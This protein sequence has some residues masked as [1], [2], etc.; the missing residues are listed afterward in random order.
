MRFLGAKAEPLPFKPVGD[1]I[2]RPGS[3]VS[4]T[5]IKNN[6]TSD[7]AE[8]HANLNFTIDEPFS[9]HKIMAA[10]QNIS[11]D[12]PS[13]SLVPPAQ[14]IKDRYA[15]ER[16]D[17]RHLPFV[18]ID[19]ARTSIID[20]ALYAE[21][22]K[23]GAYDLY[24]AIASTAALIEPDSQLEQE[25]RSR[26]QN[27]YLPGM[28]STM[29]PDQISRQLGTLNPQEDK[30]ALVCKMTIDSQGHLDKET[31][32]FM[33]ATVRSHA[34]L[35]YDTVS[36]H[37]SEGNRLSGKSGETC[38]LLNEIAQK[39]HTVIGDTPYFTRNNDYYFNVD[40]NSGKL[41]SVS[42]TSRGSANDLVQDL[43]ITANI[44]AGAWLGEKQQSQGIYRT[45]PG[46]S[47]QK[48]LKAVL[49]S[50]HI[51]LK[52]NISS[53]EGFREILTLL[54]ND[55]LSASGKSRVLSWLTSANY[56]HQPQAHLG[57]G[58]EFYLPW[59]SPLRRYADLVNHEIVSEKIKPAT[60]ES[61]QQK[62][63]AREEWL[64]SVIN[65]AFTKQLA[66]QQ[67]KVKSL[68]K[69][70]ERALV[71][72]LIKRELE[73][74]KVLLSHAVIKEKIKEGLYKAELPQYKINTLVNLT[75][76]FKPD[77][78]LAVEIK[79]VEADDKRRPLVVS[80]VTSESKPE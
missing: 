58:T 63:R 21:R 40:E 54:E 31:I 65:S 71:L 69:A 33:H 41:I 6:T 2:L 15:A 49:E 42:E 73:A 62:D 72:D 60:Q 57:I 35:D 30:A 46:F 16:V 32:Q 28:V 67:G 74:N 17:L 22:Q 13:D 56:S 37:L 20:D 80:L 76:D 78:Q 45:H 8:I 43:M 53:T 79:K 77:Q 55:K 10:Q 51:F 68:Q 11:I 59:T 14:S 34:K 75:G 47:H 4:A 23:N 66:Q 27:I 44:A 50:E 5:L 61:V 39:R 70:V 38:V 9:L 1:M 12:N 64:D 26:G 19:G 36:A 18:T 7:V 3:M 48:E 25:A 29:L 52:N 24:V